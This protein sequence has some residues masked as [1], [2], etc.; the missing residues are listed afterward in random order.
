MDCTITAEPIL[1]T[2]EQLI[3]PD[4]IKQ[5]KDV[6]EEGVLI[7]GV[8]SIDSYQ[9]LLRQ[10]AYKSASPVRYIDRAF[11]LSC[12]GADEDVFTNE[13][14]VKVRIYHHYYQGRKKNLAI[15]NLFFSLRF[16]LKNKWHHQLQLA[17]LDQNNYILIMIKF[18]TIYSILKTIDLQLKEM[19]QVQGFNWIFFSYEIYQNNG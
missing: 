4:N 10:I 18:E 15:N 9:Y 1:A 11:T 2:S 16:I 7:T 12:A 6:T 3:L 19:Y 13:I 17:L 14:R 5:E 8:D